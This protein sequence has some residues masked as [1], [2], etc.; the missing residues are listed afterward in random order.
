MVIVLDSSVLVSAIKFRGQ[1]LEIVQM[2]VEGK[3]DI[4]ISQSIID[5]TLRVL[6]LKFK[7]TEAELDAASRIMHSCGRMVQVDQHF[8]A[9]PADPKDDHI[10]DCAVAA[11]ADAII[12]GITICLTWGVWQDRD[13]ERAGLFATWNSELNSL[14]AGREKHQTFG[15]GDAQKL[16]EIERTRIETPK[17]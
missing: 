7:A 12:S 17:A 9:V 11:N 1:P 3:V 14:I 5:E 10:V 13:V 8:D 2:G 4:A 15:F 6:Q 16:T